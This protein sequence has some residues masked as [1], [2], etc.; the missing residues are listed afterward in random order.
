MEGGGERP[1]SRS[2]RTFHEFDAISPYGQVANADVSWIGW[3]AVFSGF[4]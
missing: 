3:N 2:P 1:G 4:V